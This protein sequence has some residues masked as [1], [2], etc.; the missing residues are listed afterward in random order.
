MTLMA[1]SMQPHEEEVI[2][3]VTPKRLIPFQKGQ[4][5]SYSIKFEDGGE[6][7]RVLKGDYTSI[8]FAE[9]AIASY[10][11]SRRKQKWRK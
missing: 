2:R 4:R 8:A 3:K 9:K 5:A 10:L 7:P 6:L 11:S 1:H